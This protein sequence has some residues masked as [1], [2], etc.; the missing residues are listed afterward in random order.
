MGVRN[1]VALFRLR[2]EFMKLSVLC[3]I[4]ST[5]LPSLAQAQGPVFTIA[6]EESTVQFSVKASVAVEGKFDK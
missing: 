1:V 5:V 6:P 3:L 4:A 2:K